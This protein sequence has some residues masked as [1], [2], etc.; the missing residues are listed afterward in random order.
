MSQRFVLAIEYG[1]GSLL[2]QHFW[3]NRLRLQAKSLIVYLIPKSSK[4]FDVLSPLFQ[5]AI[6]AGLLSLDDASFLVSACQA[7]INLTDQSMLVGLW[8]PWHCF[9]E[10]RE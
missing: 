4:W 6:D 9:E 2:W 3:S 8:T 10:L 5:D 1:Q 7:G